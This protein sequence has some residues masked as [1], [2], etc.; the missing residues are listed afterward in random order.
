MSPLKKIVSLD[1]EYAA[2]AG[3]AS[4]GLS[5]DSASL[6]L[7]NNSSGNA[8]TFQSVV[9]SS[10]RGAFKSKLSGEPKLKLYYNPS[11]DL[12]NSPPLRYP[13]PPTIRSLICHSKSSGDFERSG[14]RLSEKQVALQTHPQLLSLLYHMLRMAP[15][16]ASK[17]VIKYVTDN[18]INIEQELAMLSAA[19]VNVA[20]RNLE[21]SPTGTAL[22][23]ILQMKSPKKVR[24]TGEGTLN[25]N[26]EDIAKARASSSSLASLRSSRTVTTNS[27]DSNKY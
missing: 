21:S 15:A 23:E 17:E 22:D 4:A 10:A 13:S 14:L 20:S 3:C 5:L 27:S 16:L 12:G 19:R 7:E 9:S 1:V 18:G 26:K 25:M 11:Q 2:P 24:L 6:L 8:G